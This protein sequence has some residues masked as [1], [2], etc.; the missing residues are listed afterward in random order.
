MRRMKLPILAALALAAICLVAFPAAAADGRT[1]NGLIVSIS[2]H[3]IAVKSPKSHA[4]VCGRGK[5]SPSLDGYAAGDRV[6]MACLRNARGR[7]MLAKIRHLTSS[8]TTA[9]EEAPTKFGGAITSLTDTSITLHDGDR[10]LTCALGPSSPSTD[11]FKVGQHVKVVCAGGALVAISAI[12]TSD[13][14][15]IFYGE[16]TAL[17]DHSIT[18]QTEHG[19]VT[20]KIADGSPSTAAFKVGD[21]VYMGCNASTMQLVLLKAP[22][23]SSGDGGGTTT[24]PP[25]TDPPPTHTTTGARGVLSDVTDDSVTVTTDGGQVTC[26]LGDSS[27]SVDDLNVGDHVAMACWDGVLHEIAKVT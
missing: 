3:T 21:H 1:V 4:T 11:G 5:R 26:T 8:T 17:D 10:D 6:Q 9:S 12:T 20:C 22:K 18:L 19:P 14:G 24:A 16:I 27:P 13:A 23:T 7:L 2:D 25:K 15:R